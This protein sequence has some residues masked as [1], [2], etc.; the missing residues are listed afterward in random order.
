MYNT[1]NIIIN[2]TVS[3]EHI[4]TVLNKIMCM[5][6]VVHWCEFVI[7]QLITTMFIGA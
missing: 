1:N 5:F 2:I 6:H 7:T 3:F 4:L